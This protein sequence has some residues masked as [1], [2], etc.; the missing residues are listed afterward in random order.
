M[1]TSIESAQVVKDLPVESEFYFQWHLTERCNWNCTHCYQDGNPASDLPLADLLQIVD[2]MEQALA[3]W[4]KRGT[5]SLTGGEP[6]LRHEELRAVMARVDE[7]ESFAY[8][9]ILTNGSLIS[10]E[11]ANALMKC[12]R[13]RRVQLSLE[14]ATEESNDAIRGQG[15]FQSTI[16]AIRF[17]RRSGIDVAVMTTITRANKDELSEL[18]ELLGR[19]D[20]Q[21]VA[22][23]R[24]IP[25]GRG[26]A[27]SGLVLSRDELRKVFEQIY[28]IAMN[29]P[30]LRILLYR[31]LFAIIDPEDNTVGAMCSAGNTAL[32]IMPDGMVYP[33]RRLPIPIGNILTDG[34]FKI[35]YGSEVLWRIRDPNNLGGKCRDCELLT[36][37][38]GCRAAAYFAT[39]DF[40]AEDPQCFR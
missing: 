6:F 2:R 28:N 9:D 13:L 36:Q 15:S 7:S 32:T 21:T 34:L 37:C 10:M 1:I 4:D 35:W 23:E 40:M 16:A 39:G 29:G 19:E 27:I 22:F 14:G 18:V 24:F 38:K 3:K 25:E 31:P 11:E 12:E 26:R 33:C 30:P 17:L 8:Y 5:L 20:V